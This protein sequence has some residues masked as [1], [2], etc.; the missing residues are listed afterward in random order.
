VVVPP[1]PNNLNKGSNPPFFVVTSLAGRRVFPAAILVWKKL[2]TARA[3]RDGEPDQKNNSRGYLPIVPVRPDHARK[4]NCGFYFLVHRLYNPDARPLR[5]LALKGHGTW[6][7][8]Q[9]HGDRFGLKAIK[10]IGG[11]DF[12]LSVAAVFWIP[13]GCWVSL[14]GSFPNRHSTIFSKSPCFADVGL[15]QPNQPFARIPSE[16]PA[17]ALPADRDLLSAVFAWLDTVPNPAQIFLFA[18]AKGP[19]PTEKFTLK[20]K[21]ND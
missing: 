15:N 7:R 19:T 13:N 1:R 2:S 12:T 16:S 20:P 10:K 14:Q 9:C 6:R 8:A 11:P 5:R 17:S 4:T 3:P 18:S 21:K